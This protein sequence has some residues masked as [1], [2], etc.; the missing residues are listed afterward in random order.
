MLSAATLDVLG[1]EHS[2]IQDKL[3]GV[4]GLVRPVGIST[5]I[6]LSVE[7]GAKALFLG[8]YAAFTEL[9]ML[10]V[11]ILGRDIMDMFAVIVDWPGKVVALIS[12]R[13]SYHIETSR[14]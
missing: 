4:G 1:L 8:S 2:P 12:Q 7:E 5:E 9:E 3:G 13:H 10:D 6:R 14:G 11:S